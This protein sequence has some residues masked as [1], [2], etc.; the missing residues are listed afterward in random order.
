MGCHFGQG[1]YFAEPLPAD[2]AVEHLYAEHRELA[3]NE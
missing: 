2:L 1:F 3:V